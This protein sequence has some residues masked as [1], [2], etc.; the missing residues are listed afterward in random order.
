MGML[1]KIAALVACCLT[2]NDLY[3]FYAFKIFKTK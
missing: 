1:K 3:G 2:L